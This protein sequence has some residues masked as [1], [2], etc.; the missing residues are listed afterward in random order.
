MRRQ[1]MIMGCFLL[2]L[3]IVVFSLCV[4]AVRGT[5]NSRMEERVAGAFAA[6]YE[7]SAVSDGS[8]IGW[9]FWS[10]WEQILSPSPITMFM[11]TGRMPCWTRRIFSMM[12]GLLMLAEEE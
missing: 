1:L 8:G 12:P 11:I 5:R 2:I 3:V 4:R 10:R 9:N 6:Q 7:E